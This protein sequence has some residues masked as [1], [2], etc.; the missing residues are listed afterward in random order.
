MTDDSLF[1]LFENCTLPNESFR[2]YDHVHLAFIYLSKYRGLEA[3][4]RFS[5]SLLRFATAKGKPTLYHETITWA[6]LLIIRDRMARAGRSQT[7]EEF[8]AGNADLLT[9][10]DSVL[11]AYY[12]EETLTSE[13]AKK[14]FLFPDKLSGSAPDGQSSKT[15]ASRVPTH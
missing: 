1:E 4:S 12:R 11:K 14:V 3:L 9:W 8:A 7:W 15:V 13:L 5:T 2:H 10:K 6:Y